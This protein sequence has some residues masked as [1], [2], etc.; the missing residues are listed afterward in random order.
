MI[1]HMI[2]RRGKRATADNTAPRRKPCSGAAP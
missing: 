2:D 1:A